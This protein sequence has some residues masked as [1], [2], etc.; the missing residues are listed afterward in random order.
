MRLGIVRHLIAHARRQTEQ[1]SIP[2]LGYEF[3]RDTEENVSLLTPM[4]RPMPLKCTIAASP[5]AS[6]SQLRVAVKPD[7]TPARGRRSP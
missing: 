7:N 5:H 3:A 1:S 4:I 2:Q 6:A